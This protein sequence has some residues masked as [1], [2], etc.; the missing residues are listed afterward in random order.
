MTPEAV[1]DFIRKQIADAKNDYVKDLDALS[2]EQ[3]GSSPKGAARC[4]YDFTYE[5]VFIS[6]RLAKRLRGETPEPI[7]Q[8]EGWMKAPESFKNKETA[9]AEVDGS[10]QEILDAWDKL[11]PAHLQTPIKLPTSETNAISL[12]H[13]AAHHASYHDAQLNYLQAMHGDDKVHWE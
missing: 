8:D 5:V 12:G 3:L 10:M 11:D 9:K 1:K 13:M 2:D 6:R 4:P 7:T